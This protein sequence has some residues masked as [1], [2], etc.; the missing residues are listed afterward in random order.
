MKLRLSIKFEY[1]N[2]IMEVWFISV[3]LK[4]YLFHRRLHPNYHFVIIYKLAVEFEN[5]YQNKLLIPVIN[6]WQQLMPI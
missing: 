2:D 5:Y 3:I 6:G 4:L 1:V